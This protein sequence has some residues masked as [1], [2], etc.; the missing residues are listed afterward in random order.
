MA[1]PNS[2]PIV[3]LLY[4][5]AATPIWESGRHYR[6]A[7]EILKLVDLIAAE[8]AAFRESAAAF[9]NPEA[10]G[11][12][13]RAQRSDARRSWSKSWRRD[14]VALITDAGMPGLSDPGARSSGMHR[15]RCSLYDRAGS[16]GN[17]DGAGGFRNF[18]GVVLLSRLSAGQKRAAR[19]GTT[20]SGG[21]RRDHRIFESP[22]RIAKTL[23]PALR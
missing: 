20:R 22:Y 18:G 8:D 21:T 1:Q 4:V 13:S 19:A 9:R 5:V 3:S 2:D 6:V 17:F 15:A 14:N 12:L 16:I 10:D 23:A 11:Q 7:L